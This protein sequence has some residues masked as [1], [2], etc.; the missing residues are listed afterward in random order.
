MSRPVTQHHDKQDHHHSESPTNVYLYAN[1]AL[2]PLNPPMSAP[3]TPTT[4]A[5]A[6][7]SLTRPRLAIRSIAVA[8][9]QHARRGEQSALE[10]FISDA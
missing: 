1:N 4:A 10:F 3:V 7:A 8:N 5:L 6:L 9:L 2:K